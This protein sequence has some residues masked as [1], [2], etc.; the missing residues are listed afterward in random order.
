MLN[1]TFTSFLLDRD[2]SPGTIAQFG[3]IDGQ[4]PLTSSGIHAN[5]FLTSSQQRM[6]GNLLWPDLHLS[7]YGMSHHSSSN[8][9]FVQVLNLQ[10]EVAENFF[11]HTIGLDSFSIIISGGRPRSRGRVSL[12]PNATI[13]SP[14]LINPKYFS[15]PE[16]IEVMIDGIYR[17]LSLVENS[18]A[19]Q[20]IGATLFPVPF[21]SCEG[22]EFRSKPYWSCYLRHF[23]MSGNNLVGSCGMG[24]NRKEGVV[25]GDLKVFGVD[26]LRII[27]A[28]VMPS[29]PVGGTLAPTMVIAEKGADLL[30]TAWDGHEFPKNIMSR[31]YL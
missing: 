15:A 4:G 30:R 16:D 29:I 20:S 25:D 13:A 12:P 7:L 8:Q 5:A 24:K 11:N 14:P 6:R 22:Y 19:F 17:A 23:T 27:D 28:S 31:M 18:A 2:L 10:K 1:T 9:E 26:R 3:L 21:P